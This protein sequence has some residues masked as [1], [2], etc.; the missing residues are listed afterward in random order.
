MGEN[1]DDVF[2]DG[3]SYDDTYDTLDAADEVYGD[4]VFDD[5]VKTTKATPIK[6]DP[7]A[8]KAAVEEKSVP[9]K[10]PR[11]PVRRLRVAFTAALL[12]I[13]ALVVIGVGLRLSSPRETL[14][15]T[16]TPPG[17]LTAGPT[18]VAAAWPD[19][20]AYLSHTVPAMIKNVLVAPGEQQGYLFEGA[21][22]Q[23]WTITVAPQPESGLDPQITLYGPSG[24]G[25]GTSNDRTTGDVTAELVIALPESGSYRLLVE[26]AQEGATTGSYLLT[27]YVIE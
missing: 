10:T 26:S 9:P 21:A 14:V 25:V 15:I 17:P 4:A 16:A 5:D 11:L 19:S 12:L 22:G 20:I 13:A 1:G 3:Y 7:T 27:L 8:K 24:Q 18:P 2:E 6:R 23:T